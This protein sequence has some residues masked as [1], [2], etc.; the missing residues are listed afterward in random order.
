MLI[1][2]KAPLHSRCLRATVRTKGFVKTDL[3]TAWLLSAEFLS[4][5]TLKRPQFTR[6]SGRID[7]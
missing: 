2:V 1:T 5:P 7:T 4:T 6:K 3:I